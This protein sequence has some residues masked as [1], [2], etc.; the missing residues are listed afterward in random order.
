MQSLN[1][2]LMTGD[3]E[4][5]EAAEHR[6]WRYKES[7]LHVT[8]SSLKSGQLISWSRSQSPY[9]E[10][11]D[12]EARLQEPIARTYIMSQLDPIHN[13]TTHFYINYLI[14]YAYAP[15]EYVP[16]GVLDGYSMDISFI[17]V[18]VCVCVCVCN[19]ANAQT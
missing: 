9:V 19:N 2:E 18:C 17:C 15:Q 10:P 13:L 11:Q 7:Q 16:F 12:L 4:H 3:H 8:V 14:T 5:E 6:E 1:A